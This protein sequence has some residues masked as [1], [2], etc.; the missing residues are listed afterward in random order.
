MRPTVWVGALDYP[1]DVR[2]CG[3][4]DAA[5]VVM[6]PS[7][8]PVTAGVLVHQ[9]WRAHGHVDAVTDKSLLSKHAAE[10]YDVMRTPSGSR[11]VPCSLSRVRMRANLACCL[12]LAGCTE[13]S[14]DVPPVAGCPCSVQLTPVVAVGHNAEDPAPYPGSRVDI[15][16]KGRY[17]IA[18]NTE[19]GKVAVYHANGALSHT[20]GG[21]GS[22]PGEFKFPH[23]TFISPQDSIFVVDRERNFISVFS[24]DGQFIRMITTRG[25]SPE[26]AFFPNGS[27]IAYFQLSRG[28][29]GYPV[30][31]L[32]PDGSISRSFGA[33][34]AESVTPKSQRSIAPTPRYTV[35]VGHSAEYL[36][37]EYD[38]TGRV[39]QSIRRTVTWY[40]KQDSI[41]RRTRTTIDDIHYDEST[42]RLWVLIHK[43]NPNPDLTKIG[44]H[45][46]NARGESLA[47]I[48]TVD[49]LDELTDWYLEAIDVKSQSVLATARVPNGHFLPN[50]HYYYYVDDDNGHTS[51]HV[52]RLSLIRKELT[53]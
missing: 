10:L 36:L 31:V 16:S 29:K 32:S 22:G 43:A 5:S 1:L 24:P 12:L 3:T 6:L 2:R 23:K 52:A 11:F 42:D 14:T 19:P 41:S 47:R 49:E 53:N 46:V 17:Y 33:D 30:H 39:L 7:N 18:W 48:Y 38:T 45:S 51:I 20:I 40:P 37:E 15:D 25:S 9:V 8:G 34:R 28:Q 50:G 21:L 35:W 27:L 44:S 13:A 26:I 4:L